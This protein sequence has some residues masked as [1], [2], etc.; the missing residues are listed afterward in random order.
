MTKIKDQ[1]NYYF[2]IIIYFIFVNILNG[3]ISNIE[4]NNN[5]TS[6]TDTK[7]KIGLLLPVGSKN[8]DL[9][10]LGKSLRDAAFLAKEDLVNSSFEIK[11]YDTFG[12]SKK[13][14]I[15]YNLA[16]EEKNEIIVGPFV[17]IITKEI[18]NNFP[19]NNLKVIS[20]SS[21]PLI[22]GTNIF[23]LGDTI[24]NRANNLIRFAIN[25]N[26]YR[27][28]LISPTNDYSAVEKILI[29]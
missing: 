11:T 24:T 8:R 6:I 7:T 23:L 1:R 25:N 28:A 2:Y 29:N 14:L 21:D 26:K 3:C 22:N 16:L 13:G 20:L 27:F 9:S 17:P 4:E 10:Y 5:Y 12:K 15:A 18:S 19:F